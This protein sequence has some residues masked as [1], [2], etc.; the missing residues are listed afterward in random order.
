MLL[1]PWT[2]HVEISGTDNKK[3]RLVKC[4]KGH[5]GAKRDRRKK[6]VI[7]LIV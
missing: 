6:Q 2:E 4:E 5:I 1:I 3:K 7:Y